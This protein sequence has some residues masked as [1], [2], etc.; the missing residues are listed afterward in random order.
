MNYI[1]YSPV[2]NKI[3]LQSQFQLSENSVYLIGELRRK[4]ISDGLNS[5]FS[6]EKSKSDSRVCVYTRIYR[7]NNFKDEND[8]DIQETD[9]GAT[10]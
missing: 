10:D 3:K 7:I 8:Q 4:K 1:E 2:L 5:L 9:R 6:W